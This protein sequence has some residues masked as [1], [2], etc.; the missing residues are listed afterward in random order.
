MPT[1]CPLMVAFT[2]SGKPR[3]LYCGKW[4][5]PNCRGHN[6]GEWARDGRYGV[7][8]TVANRFTPVFWTLTLGTKYRTAKEGYQ[9]LPRLWDTFRKALQRAYGTFLYMAFVEGQAE[10]NDM[11][12]FHIIAYARVPAGFSKRRDK[13]KHIKDF[14]V[15]MGFGHQAKEI[16]ITSDGAFWYIMKYV[17]KSTPSMPANFR[18]CRCS[19]GWKRAPRPVQKPFIVRSIGE[20]I[21]D[22]L[23]RVQDISGRDLDDLLEEYQTA[24]LQMELARLA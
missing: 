15:A 1:E 24:S 18:R 7:N 6:A 10:R 22:Y 23:I 21:Q 12:H 3:M 13:R 5:C 4:S 19:R 11:P 14:A 2:Q 9:A 8:R 17:S 20:L 16:A